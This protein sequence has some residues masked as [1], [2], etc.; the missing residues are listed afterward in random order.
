MTGD[1]DF[2]ALDTLTQLGKANSYCAIGIEWAPDGLTMMSSVL[3]E[4][5][6]VDNMIGVFTG[7]GKKLLGKG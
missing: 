3:Y 7:S 6:K 5:V 1:A 2:W 4:R